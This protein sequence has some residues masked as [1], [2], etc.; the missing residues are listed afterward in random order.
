MI[1]GNPRIS[2]LRFMVQSGPD[3]ASAAAES[4]WSS[5]DLPRLPSAAAIVGNMAFCFR[6]WEQEDYFS[7]PS[8]RALINCTLSAQ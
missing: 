2:S 7:P 1:L 8:L 5:D 4:C 6:P 3:A